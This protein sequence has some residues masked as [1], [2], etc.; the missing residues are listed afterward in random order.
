M[1]AAMDGTSDDLPHW[2][3]PDVDAIQECYRV[4]GRLARAGFADQRERGA[5]AVFDWL[6]LGES[7]PLTE[8]TGWP[9]TFEH[10]RAESWVALCAAAAMPPPTELDWQRLGASPLPALPVEQEFAYGAWRALAWLL[11][12]R[13]D[14]PVQGAWHR[15]AGV[16]RE[17]AH[18]AVPPDQ[19][20][21][22]AWKTAEQ[23]YRDQAQSDALRYWQHVRSMADATAQSTR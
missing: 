23:S 13:D 22:A 7:A 20:D 2:V 9:V 17:R 6:V 16:P 19:R 1:A 8:R 11:G 21:T 4:A 3:V 10:A 5:L 15:A 12:V 14:W 18:V